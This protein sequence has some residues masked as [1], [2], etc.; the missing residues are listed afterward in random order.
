MV[1][2]APLRA[3][4]FLFQ[5]LLQVAPVVPAGQEIGDSGAQQPRAVDRIFDADGGDRAQMREKIRAMMAR[6]SRRI[7]AAEA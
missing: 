2:A 1:P 6:E 3:R 5:A 7:A 4:Q